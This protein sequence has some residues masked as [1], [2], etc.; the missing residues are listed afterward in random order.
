MK[1]KTIFAAIVMASSA[2]VAYADDTVVVPEKAVRDYVNHLGLCAGSAVTLT[3]ETKSNADKDLFSLDSDILTAFMVETDKRISG[4]W[5][6]Y[7]KSMSIGRQKMSDA[8][9]SAGYDTA[10]K[11]YNNS[12]ATD[13]IQI[14]TSL[15]STNPDLYNKFKV[16]IEEY[17]KL[18]GSI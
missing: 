10:S 14:Y 18:H 16:R 13:V 1:I 9:G 2:S 12:C 6:D 4:Y 8:I 3:E 7:N 17:Q 5:D 15:E 11:Y